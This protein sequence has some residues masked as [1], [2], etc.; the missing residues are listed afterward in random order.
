MTTV[1][2]VVGF[3]TMG[4]EIALLGSLAGYQ[5]MAFDAYPAILDKS[6]ARLAKV[7]KLLGRD[8]KFFAAEILADDSKREAV[9]Q[10]ISTVTELERVG[11]LS[12]RNQDSAG[13][14]SS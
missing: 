13:R 7:A 11:S 9:L 3:G 2:G 5:V 6:M 14:H 12:N 8:P 4:S 1:L 10:R